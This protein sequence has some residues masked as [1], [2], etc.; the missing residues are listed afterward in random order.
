M[1]TLHIV[2]LVSPT[3]L[4]ISLGIGGLA[5]YGQFKRWQGRVDARLDSGGRLMHDVST[6]I[7]EHEKFCA[8]HKQNI[9]RRLAHIEGM[10]DRGSQKD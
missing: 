7:E 4:L 6:K 10:L 2:L 3:M 9:E 1:T 8:E 5:A